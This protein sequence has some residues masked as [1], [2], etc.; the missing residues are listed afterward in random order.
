MPCVAEPVL[1]KQ[2]FKNR[3]KDTDFFRKNWSV[4]KKFLNDPK[5]LYFIIFNSAAQSWISIFT[6]A[7]VNPY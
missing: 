5:M 3:K 1:L 6:N 7:E 4:T 2:C